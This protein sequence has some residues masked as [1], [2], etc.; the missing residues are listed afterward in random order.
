MTAH[1]PARPVP[2]SLWRDRRGAAAVEMALLSPIL[3]MLFL[4]TVEVTQLIRVKTKLALAAQAIE[5]MVAGQ[6]SATTAS[7]ANAY[8]GGV[9]VMTPFPTSG[10]TATVA[11][12][13]FNASGSAA[14]VDWQVLEGGATGMTTAAACTLAAQMG[15]GSDS[16]IVVKATFAYTPVLSYLLGQSYALVQITYGRPRNAATVSGPTSTGATGSC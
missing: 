16:V 13:S 6:T 5:D 15:L 4:G 7:L 3:V 1:D 9:L 12:V 2:A 11:S 10:L 14:T 8:A